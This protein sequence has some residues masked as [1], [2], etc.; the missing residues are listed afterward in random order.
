MFLGVSLDHGGLACVYVFQ[1][2]V[3]L[4]QSTE[5]TVHR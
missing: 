5:Y 3:I 4:L 1:N 2:E